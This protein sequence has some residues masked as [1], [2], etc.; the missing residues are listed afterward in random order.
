MCMRKGHGGKL[1]WAFY[2]VVF[3]VSGVLL[4]PQ[5][6]GLEEHYDIAQV[7]DASVAINLDFS[8]GS[9]Q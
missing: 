2:L 3:G 6:G 9:L 7:K 5:G 4:I 8:N 1:L